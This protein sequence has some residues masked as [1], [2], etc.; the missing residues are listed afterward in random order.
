MAKRLLS[1][2]RASGKLHIGNYFGAMKQFV[3]FQDEYESF[4][5]V[6]NYHSLTTLKDPK[7]LRQNTIDVVKDYL[8]VGLDPEKVTLY[9]QTDVPEVTELAWIFSTLTTMPYLMRAHAYKDAESKNKEINVG[10]FNYPVL[11]AADILI[12][13]TDVVPVGKDQQQHVEMSKDI[14]Q[15]FN[16]TFGET[17]KLPKPLILNE[18]AVIPGIDGEKMSKSY[19]NTIPLFGTDDEIKTQVAKIITDS[20]P[21]GEIIDPEKDNVFAL[22]KLFSKD[23]LAELEKKYR[24]G[25]IGHKESKDILAENIIKLISPMRERRE[26]ISDE[27]VMEVLKKGAERVQKI[28]KVKLEEVRKKAG[29]L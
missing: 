20:T 23:Q 8:A 5:F 9:T 28:A 19:N 29:L 15:K 22:H 26:Q 6:A 27:D 13:D 17:F 12:V 4:I 10:V 14:A 3:D 16:N 24:E 11:M 7:E 1:G 21:V 25:G 2:I 18:V